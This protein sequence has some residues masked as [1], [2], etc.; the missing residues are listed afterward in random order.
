MWKLQSPA[1]PC[2][3]ATTSSSANTCSMYLMNDSSFCSSRGRTTH[4]I[5]GSGRFPCP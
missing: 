4:S 1:C 3:P 2:V 5:I